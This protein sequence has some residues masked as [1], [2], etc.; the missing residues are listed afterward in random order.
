MI[1]L[2]KKKVEEKA[3]DVAADT[4]VSSA[5]SATT[6]APVADVA[7]SS[8]GGFTLLGIDGKSS[9]SNGAKPV[10]KK[11]KTPGE[12]RIQKGNTAHLSTIL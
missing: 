4:L 8:G 3:P 11:Q 7:E 6:T 1:G 5:A 9:R 10:A 12:M 2:K